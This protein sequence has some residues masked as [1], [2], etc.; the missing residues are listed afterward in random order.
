MRMC[1]HTY[2]RVLLFSM[3]SRFSAQISPLFL[4]EEGP[5]QQHTSEDTSLLEVVVAGV[6]SCP[7]RRT[8][9]IANVCANSTLWG[10]G[11]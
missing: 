2:V 7:M 1:V 9:D 11:P 10:R 4:E 6:A 8:Q 3:V 5:H